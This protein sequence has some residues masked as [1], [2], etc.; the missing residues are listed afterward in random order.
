MT[1]TTEFRTIFN[2]VDNHIKII[3]HIPTGYYNITKINNN[4]YQLKNKEKG[5]GRS[6]GALKQISDWTKLVSSKE[7]IKKLQL[8]LNNNKEVIII[9]NNV[10]DEFKG[11][12]VHRYLYDHILMWID[13]SYAIKISVILDKIHTEYNKKLEEEVKEK[14]CKIDELRNDINKQREE[15]K[16]QYEE[17][18]KFAKTGV[19]NQEE[20]KNTMEDMQED[21][22]NLT[23]KVE[24]VRDE[25]R[26]QTEHINPPPEDDDD[27]HMFVLLQYP[28][29]MDKFRI[30][31][32]QNKHLDKSITKDMNIVID[33]RYHPNPIDAFTALKDKI[34]KLD[35]EETKKIKDLYKNKTISRDDK[36]DLLDDH[37]SFPAISI[38]YNTININYKKI[39]L[40]DFIELVNKCANLGKETHIP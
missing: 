32:G 13:K 11:T 2:G 27:I 30:I 31:R 22:E 3:Q 40:N 39:T 34:K 5:S 24:E 28:N 21:I 10:I 17:L 9:I 15:M 33:R 36:N 35:K 20:M 6:S 26:E 8:Q 12:Y 14:T 29:E 37:K 25:F 1:S 38:K 4:I 7:L 18:L 16:T 23:D 19:K